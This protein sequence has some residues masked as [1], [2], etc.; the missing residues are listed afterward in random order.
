MRKGCGVYDK[1][2]LITGAGGFIAAHLVQR[3]IAEGGPVHALV[4]PTTSLER[5]RPF[6][7]NV[8]L[9]FADLCN[10]QDVQSCVRAIAPGRVFHLAAETRLRSEH[11][12]SA[13]AQFT[14]VLTQ[15]FR[16]PALNLVE[17]LADLP[18]P[19]DV[20][21][22]AGTIAEYGAVAL[23]YRESQIPDPASAYGRGMLLTSEALAA[24]APKLPFPVITARLAL[25]YGP[26]QSRSFLIPALIDACVSRRAITVQRPADRR[27]L[28]HVSDA[29]DAFLEISRI[30]P[31]QCGI[32]NIGTG[33][34]PS[35]DEVAALIE[36]ATGCPPGVVSRARTEQQN[37]PDELRCDPALARKVL[38][39]ESRIDLAEG[40][41]RT[42]MAE[43]SMRT[44][45]R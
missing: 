3:L 33:M 25:C 32:I 14:P 31:A 7:A 17:A 1:A 9:H 34:A 35:M 44:E 42:V 20:F 29:V 39:W 23:P 30:V 40:L 13:Q 22:R 26:G 10:R 37:D 18:Q 11:Q 4:R 28:L 27:D 2:T 21:L 15:T 43:I 5:L 24:L 12:S 19:P 6:G 36:A 38:G 45:A 41:E 16:Q 8:H